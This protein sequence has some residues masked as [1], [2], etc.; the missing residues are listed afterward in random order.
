[1]TGMRGRVERAGK[2]VRWARVFA[3]RVGMPRVIG[4][5]HGDDRGEFLLLIAP[6]AS[7]E[8]ELTNPL[9]IHFEIRVPNPATAPQPPKQPGGDPFWDLPV[10]P[11]ADLIPPD[12]EADPVSR[13]DALP[14]DYIMFTSRNAALVL[15]EILNVGTLNSP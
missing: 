14:P 2:P 15:G 10:E 1:M 8:S 4:R 13:G 11:A 6:E 9:N 5:A 3:T 12:Y 7:N